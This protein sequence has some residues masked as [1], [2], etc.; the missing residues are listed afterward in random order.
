ML[1][2]KQAADNLHF[3]ILE[4]RQQ[5]ERTREYLSRPSQELFEEVTARDDHIDNLKTRIQRMCF[6]A[7]AESV[8]HNGVSLES[9]KAVEVIAA[10]LENIADFCEKVI[11][12]F[13]YLHHPEAL[14]LDNIDPFFEEILQAVS[15]IEE[16][17]FNR[18]VE[19]AQKI[20]R[21][22]PR[23]DD[24]YDEALLDILDKLKTSK[25]TQSLVTS[26]FIAHYFERMGDSLLNIGEAVIS[27][28]LGERF[29][30]G[31]FRTLMASLEG[32]GPP[33][34]VED[35]QLES[36]AET[37]S[38]A[39]ID[40]VFNTNGNGSEQTVVLKQGRAAKLIQEKECLERW[41]KIIP[42]LTPRIC[43][44]IQNND[45]AALLYEYLPGHT[46]EELIAKG[47]RGDIDVAVERL[48]NTTAQVWDKT[49][50]EGPVSADFT[51]QILNRLP[52]VYAVHPE[53]RARNGANGKAAPSFDAMV[54][55]SRMI[56]ARLKA[57]FS[58]LTHGDFNIDN[59]IYDHK[60]DCIHFIDLHRS[61]ITD[62]VQDVSVFLVSNYR[63]PHLNQIS[64][65]RINRV[66]L[67]FYDFACSY[68]DTA[69]DPT[70][71]ARLA[72]GLARSYATSTR[73]VRDAAFADILFDKSRDLM[74]HLAAA[75][76]G[77][78]ETFQIPREALVE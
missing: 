69:N 46:L 9:L 53:F 58:V 11:R 42:G 77:R 74:S 23:L 32:M 13:S 1:S 16:A 36:L 12:Q 30:I 7:A 24:L 48:C 50:Q 18:N 57:P 63:L 5:L 72:L 26:L 19:I 71:R 45:K 3:L 35:I 47:T 22:E 54:K 44:F 68:A 27:A 14:S 37:H 51:S 75:E 43:S 31:Q 78:F 33:P 59:I 55:E 70:F 64:R 49:R 15:L 34:S 66:I 41:S 60:R 28:S 6:A 21:A 62:Y 39:R 56:D 38:G 4:V 10:N 67:Q 17:V 61:R 65:S 73:F 20:C 52:H 2:S 29:K 25:N 40:R 76:G 8:R